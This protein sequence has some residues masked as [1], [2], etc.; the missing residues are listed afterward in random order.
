MMNAGADIPPQPATA[1]EF[2]N[3]DPSRKRSN[4]SAAAKRIE[5]PRR[6]KP[7]P[8]ALAEWDAR[9]R[10]RIGEEI[11]SGKKIRF[12]VAAFQQ[13]FEVISVDEAGTLDLKGAVTEMNMEWPRLTPADKKS[14]AL[15][16]LREGSPEDHCFAAFY[17]I[18]SGDEKAA[19]EHLAKGGDG[20]AGVEASFV[21]AGGETVAGGAS[22][23]EGGAAG[24]AEGAEEGAKPAQHREPRARP[25]PKPAPAE[26]KPPPDAALA[27]LYQEAETAFIDGDV[28]R[29]KVLFEKIVEGHPDSPFAPKAKEYLAILE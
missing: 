9:L 4:G 28:E 16:V 8:G 13:R 25:A 23:A 2:F 6:R 10:A 21:V 17:L 18:A 20:A 24:G 11:A 29:A 19:E 1:A 15:A 22:V 3:V 7:K 26:E 14:L 12:S 27:K 5:M